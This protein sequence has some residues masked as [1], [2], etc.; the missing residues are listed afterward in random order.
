MA[1]ATQRNETLKAART[2]WNLSIA[3]TARLAQL[4]R[5]TVWRLET[6]RRKP[7]YD[8]ITALERVLKTRLRFTTRRTAA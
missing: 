3:E 7:T 4:D 5:V 1:T 6:G 8:T 2:R